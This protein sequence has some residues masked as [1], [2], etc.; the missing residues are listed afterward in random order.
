MAN[1]IDIPKVYNG[2]TVVMATNSK[3][4]TQIDPG[5]Q[6]LPSLSAWALQGDPDTKKLGMINTFGQMFGWSAPMY[7]NWFKEGAVL[8]VNGFNGKFSYEMPTFE[9]YAIRTVKDTSIGVSNAGIDGSLFELVLNVKL[10]P[11]TII[12]NDQLYG[13]QIMVSEE[14]EPTPEG[15]GWKHYMTLIDSAGDR[16]YNSEFLKSDVEYFVG[17]TTPIGEFT[18]RFGAPRFM[19]GHST[20]KAEFQLGNARGLEATTTAFADSKQFSGAMVDVDR[21]MR[22]IKNLERRYGGNSVVFSDLSGLNKDGVPVGDRGTMRIS[23]LLEVLI[24]NELLREEAWQNTF[25]KA[26]VI[27][28]SNG[29]IRLNEG[30]YQQARRGHRIQYSRKGGLTVSHLIQASEIIHQGRPDL[31]DTEKYLYLTGG[32]NFYDNVSRIIQE[33]AIQ[34]VG[35]LSALTGTDSQLPEKIITGDSLTDLEVKPVKFTKA[36]IPEVGNV[37]VEH[38]M[39]FDYQPNTDR[40]AMNVGRHSLPP[41]SFSGVIWDISDPEYTSALVD[42]PSGAKIKEGGNMDANVYYIKPEGRNFFFGKERGR[43]SQTAGEIVSSTNFLGETYWAWSVSAGWLRD[44]TK[45]LVFELKE[46]PLP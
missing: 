13:E 17:V 39:T 33:N 14:H 43:Y 9:N 44:K 36:Y 41:T 4:L 29:T 18:E 45:T 19:D 5:W 42:L 26:A 37:K 31:K 40:R 7:T 12:Y 16:S 8:E 20:I 11:N 3:K 25:Q 35:N 10:D 46:V 23:S 24:A 1:R 27:K 21:Y 6:D 30:V 22:N 2:D 28:N 38:D 15:G 34:Q 32:R